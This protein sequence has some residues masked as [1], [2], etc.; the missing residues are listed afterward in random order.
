MIEYMYNFCFDRF[1][2]WF[3]WGGG[4]IDMLLFIVLVEDGFE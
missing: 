1:C 3:V 2:L 4:Y